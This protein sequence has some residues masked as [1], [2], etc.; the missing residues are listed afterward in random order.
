MK[1]RCQLDTSEHPLLLDATALARWETH[2][3]LRTQRPYVVLGSLRDNMLYPTWADPGTKHDGSRSSSNGAEAP[4]GSA[5]TSGS[6][7]VQ[8]AQHVASAATGASSSGAQAS[9]NG[10]TPS[11]AAGADFLNTGVDNAD[12]Q[13]SGLAMCHGMT[14]ED[15]K[16]LFP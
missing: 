16:R 1:H 12:W 6:P 11:P 15:I 3:A 13:H 7:E 10:S 9:V 5:S 2:R 8:P 4:S 14:T